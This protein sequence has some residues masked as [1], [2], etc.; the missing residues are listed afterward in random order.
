VP[1]GFDGRHAFPD[2]NAAPAPRDGGFDRT[3]TAA[4]AVPSVAPPPPPPPPPPPSDASVKKFID[5]T[6]HFVAKN[7]AW[8]EQMAREKQ[9][10]DP[11]F[12]FLRDP[13]SSS[14]ARYYAWR[15]R[16]SRAELSRNAGDAAAWAGRHA[17]SDIS[18]IAVRRRPL[19][20]DDRARALGEEPLASSRGHKGVDVTSV[21]A[22]DRT[23]IASALSGAFVAGAVEGSCSGDGGLNRGSLPA[24]LTDAASLLK[25]KELIEREKTEARLEAERAAAAAREAAAPTVSTRSS[26]DWA[27]AAL[28]CKRFGVPDP[29]EL[30][31]G[32]LRPT[33]KQT[34]LRG[35]VPVGD[36]FGRRARGD[37]ETKQKRGGRKRSAEFDEKKRAR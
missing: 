27:P 35:D 3:E 20:V 19:H 15:L 14:A 6:A 23:K 1:R 9:R 33:R 34:A 18:T 26:F 4:A 8:F 22:G 2:E 5:T 32:R 13:A 30:G 17:M 31:D 29:F 12:A 24:G 11:R 36:L 28:L 25:R 16:T 21:A 10:A 37:G 7:G